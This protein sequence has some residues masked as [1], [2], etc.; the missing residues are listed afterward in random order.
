MFHRLIAS[1]SRLHGK[2]FT[3]HKHAASDPSGSLMFPPQ[4]V[5]LPNIGAP[6]MSYHIGF[7]DL[8]LSTN[9]MVSLCSLMI[10]AQNHA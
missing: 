5:E 2:L 10:C 4:H 9:A 3:A 6:A 7:V 8:H 1:G